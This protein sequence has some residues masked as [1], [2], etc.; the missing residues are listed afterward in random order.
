MCGR[1]TI[2]KKYIE[3]R[4]ELMKINARYIRSAAEPAKEVIQ[5]NIKIDIFNMLQTTI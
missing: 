3:G 4:K 2:Y 5:V 1:N